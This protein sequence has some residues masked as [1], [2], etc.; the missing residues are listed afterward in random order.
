MGLGIQFGQEVHIIPV[1]SPLDIIATDVNSTPIKV[2]N[3]LRVS[4]LMSFGVVD[5]DSQTIFIRE[6]SAADTVSAEKIPFTYRLSGATGS[7]TWG[8]VTTA[9]SGGLII[10]ASDDEKLLLIDVDPAT[11]T[12]GDNYLAVFIVTESSLTENVIGIQAFLWPRYPQL[13]HVSTT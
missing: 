13:D 12:E 11:L 9:D 5:G 3:A 7:D 4:F 10:S 6:S 1:M 8:A 2:S